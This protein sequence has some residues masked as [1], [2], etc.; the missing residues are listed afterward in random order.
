[1]KL[2]DLNSKPRGGKGLRSII[3]CALVAFLYP[4]PVSE[5]YKLLFLYQLYGTSYINCDQ[6]KISE[7]RMKISNARN[8]TTKPCANQI[9]KDHVF[10]V[11]F[12]C[13][14]IN[15]QMMT[16]HPH[17]SI[18]ISFIFMDTN[19][20]MIA[21]HTHISIKDN[22]SSEK[23]ASCYSIL[24]TVTYNYTYEDTPVR[25]RI[26]KTPRKTAI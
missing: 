9:K 24:S 13:T 7:V 10:F 22:T 19:N 17:L 20:R 12:I 8:C 5:H 14:D 15:I 18:L 3:D 4:N 23:S 1:M 25:T 11:S 16:N 6:N 26:K 2:A 21:N